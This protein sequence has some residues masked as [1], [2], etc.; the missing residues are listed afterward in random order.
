MDALV[1][2]T[3]LPAGVAGLRAAGSGGLG[4]VAMGPSARTAG[5]WSRF[6]RASAVAPDVLDDPVGFATAVGRL[7]VEHGPLVVYPVQEEAIDA[8]IDADLPAEAMLPY[9]AAQAVRRLRDKRALPG[10]FAEGGFRTAATLAEGTASEL[11]EASL[12]CPCVLKPTGKGG[13]MG[14]AEVM[15]SE[16]HLHS[17]LTGL[18]PHEPLLVQERLSSPMG[19]LALVVARDGRLVARFQHSVKRTSRLGTTVVAAASRQTSGWLS[20]PQ[21]CSAAQVTSGSR[22]STISIP[23]RGPAFID[24][25]PRFYG[26]MPLAGAA[27]VNLPVAWHSVGTNG[28]A[29][30][31]G[32]LRIGVTYRWLEGDVVAAIQGAP[33]ILTRRCAPPKVG[34]MWA[35]DDPMTS[36]VCGSQILAKRVWRRVPKRVR[37]RL[38]R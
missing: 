21:R 14:T 10:L 30:S 7:A 35:R 1:T 26:S 27:G 28:A 37:R 38:K 17:V 4:V 25:N 22:S 6:A 19:S 23:P 15:R 33:D 13:A 34:D 3:H 12:P 20:A 31:P 11:L 18:P 16:A 8:L 5:L 36:V 2:E 9:P 24:V 32:D 29:G